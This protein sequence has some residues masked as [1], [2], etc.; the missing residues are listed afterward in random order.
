MEHH[1]TNHHADGREFHQASAIANSSLPTPEPVARLEPLPVAAN[2]EI[3]PPLLPPRNPAEFFKNV[4][5][6]RTSV[7]STSLLGLSDRPGGDISY[8]LRDENTSRHVLR[9]F[10]LLAVLAGLAC[11]AYVRLLPLYQA[12]PDFLKHTTSGIKYA[13]SGE[14][15]Q[16]QTSP[17]SSGSSAE[18]IANANKSDDLKDSAEA[19]GDSTVPAPDTARTVSDVAQNHPDAHRSAADVEA[20]KPSP[21]E[22]A[23]YA[24][25][26]VARRKPSLALVRA[27]QYLQG[28]GVPQNC[29]QGLVY[30]RAAALKN[31]PQAAVQLGALYSSGHCVHQDRVVAYRWL[32]SAREQEPYNQW[33]QQNLDVLWGHMS[34]QER[35]QINN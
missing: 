6:R 3:A 30:L 34:P 15:R 4:P 24:E 27:Q 13:I 19:S 18:S 33:I 31:D 1:A 7:T 9:K 29:E 25:N 22:T 20:S 10:L 17:T 12:D 35:K 14:D 32:S 2:V 11:A 5:R 21:A 23:G 8:L 16:K 26:P 28:K